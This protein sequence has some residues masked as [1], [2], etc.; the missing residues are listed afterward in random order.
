MWF[1][2]F[3]FALSI[4]FNSTFYLTFLTCFYSLH[5]SEILLC[6]F[7]YCIF[8]FFGIVVTLSVL[9][10]VYSYTLLFCFNMRLLTT[11]I[12]HIRNIS[13]IRKIRSYMKYV[14]HFFLDVSSRTCLCIRCPQENQFILG[15]IA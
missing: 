12:C 14:A 3:F 15:D 4:C 5:C 10:V 1:Y 2:F 8:L 6:C 7:E 11:T 9:R 13:H